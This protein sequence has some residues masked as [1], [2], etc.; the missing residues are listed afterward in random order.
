MSAGE[1]DS[2]EST[3]RAGMTD[4]AGRAAAAESDSPEP[5]DL[6]DEYIPLTPELVEEDAQ[7]NDF[8]LRMAAVLL[9][10]LLGCTEIGETQT[11]VHVKTGQYLAGHGVLPPRTD[12]FSYTAA[13]RPW[14]NLSWLF[15]LGVAGVYAIGSGVGLTIFKAVLAA[16]AF[17]CV[18]HTGRAGVPTWWGSIAAALALVVCFAQLTALPEIITLAGVALVLWLLSRWEQ[19]GSPRHLWLVV[20]TLVVWSN[21]DPRAFIGGLLFVA[22]AAGSL[23]GELLGRS[24]AGDGARRR[25]LALAAAAGVAALLVNPFLWHSLLAPVSLYGAESPAWR[26]Y[27]ASVST[28]KQLEAFRLIDGTYWRAYAASNIVRLITTTGLVLAAAALVCLVLNWRR[29]RLGHAAVYVLFAGLALAGSH[30]LAA[31]SIVWAV[32]ANLNAQEWYR[33]TF[34]QTYST[35]FGERLF[36]TG[37]RLVSVVGLLLIAWLAISGALAGGPADRISEGNRIG[38]GFRQPLAAEIAGLQEDLKV[39]PR[40][41]R[42]FNTVPEQGDVMIWIGRAPFIDSRLAVYAGRDEHD[43]IGQHQRARQALRPHMPLMTDSGGPQVWR[44]VFTD[45]GV[46]CVLVHLAG[47]QPDYNSYGALGATGEFG[48]TQLGSAAAVMCWTA[49]ADREVGTPADQPGLDMT[50]AAFR[51]ESVPEI[52]TRYDWAQPRGFHERLLNLPK[53]RRSVPLQKARHYDRHVQVYAEAV[54]SDG[55]SYAD[56]SAAVATAHLAIRHAHIELSNNPQV[57]EAYRILGHAY[58]LLSMLETQLNS[59]FGGSE[60]SDRRHLQAVNAYMQAATIEPRDES[61]WRRLREL[62]GVQGRYDLVLYAQKHL[63][64]SLP[65]PDELT[66]TQRRTL[67]SERQRNKQIVED[68]TGRLRA[69]NAQVDRELAHENGEGAAIQVAYQNGCVLR[70]LELIDQLD[71]ELRYRDTNIRLLEARLLLEA[72]RS[73]QASEILAG[74]EDVLAQAEGV[75]WRGWAAM[76]SLAR[77]D[78][79]H[80]VKLWNDEARSL[81]SARFEVIMDTLPLAAPPVVFFRAPSLPGWPVHHV[82]SVQ[83]A[84]SR[85][86][87]MRSIALFNA[88]ITYLEI[89]QPEKANEQFRQ[90]FEGDPNTRLRPL[91]AFYFA[92]SSDDD[93]PIDPTFPADRI[94]LTAEVFAE[95]SPATDDPAR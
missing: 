43:L 8:V 15:D 47:R 76:A 38:F 52:P 59:V 66:P 49:R 36:S 54:R 2:K 93:E 42:L 33:S 35:E 21:L 24:E 56:A 77:G 1:T 37:G 50:A 83:V 68:L 61:T 51:P 58:S 12:V 22:Y 45:H 20:G 74:L 40:D 30:E 34:R 17:W 95:D 90:L 26:E 3:V 70:A 55:L 94:P 6:P 79:L 19:G 9:A 11:L 64:E 44:D 28:V 69:V 72:G 92:R 10:L 14:V 65:D 25:V 16:I 71:E 48:L 7:R 73:Q 27:H 18:V 57:A 4:E 23:V 91:A 32:L 39:V 75:Q 82:G 86:Q 53:V 13:E 89:G 85:L 67:A 81:Q 60:W 78:F 80:A 87:D 88:A 63:D 46:D 31:A 41:H 84:H 29:A 5:A 62:F